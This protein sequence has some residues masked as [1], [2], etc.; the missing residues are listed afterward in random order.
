MKNIL[1]KISKLVS[2]FFLLF[3][4]F[5][6]ILTILVSFKPIK[7]NN[8]KALD[9]VRILNDY[10]VKEFGN[11]FLSF[12]NYSRNYE[13]FIE[14][15]RTN[16]SLIPNVLLGVRLK[17]ILFLKFKPT[18]LKLYDA[19]LELNIEKEN[20][21]QFIQADNLL[22]FFSKKINSIEFIE[23]LN[24]F[25]IFEVNN[26]KFKV[27]LFESEDYQFLRIDLK[28]EK[29]DNDFDISALIEQNEKLKSFVIF[30]AKK[31]IVN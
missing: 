9:D 23:Y 22:N 31:K 29:K 1:F 19:K 21:N 20:N 16:N 15:V 8:L 10:K 14:D 11:I 12:N 30:N 17:D 4:S 18:I 27:K 25:Q 24:D 28:I 7:I 26:S 6:L 3:F 13:I 2:L 5:F